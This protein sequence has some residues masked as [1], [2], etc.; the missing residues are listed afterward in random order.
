MDETALVDAFPVL[1]QEF[2]VGTLFHRCM[3]LLAADQAL[4]Q[5]GLLVDQFRCML[6]FGHHPIVIADC[7]YTCGSGHG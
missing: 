7:R 5:A 2:P 1:R 3:I 6:L 4:H